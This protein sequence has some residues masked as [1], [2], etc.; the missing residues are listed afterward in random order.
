[1][2]VCLVESVRLF[3][4]VHYVYCGNNLP[5][6]KKLRLLKTKT[7][8]LKKKKTE[9]TASCTPTLI[10]NSPLSFSLSCLLRPLVTIQRHCP[11]FLLL[12]F[13]W[14]TCTLLPISFFLSF[15]LQFNFH[16]EETLLFESTVTTVPTFTHKEKTTYTH[17]HTSTSDLKT[18]FRFTY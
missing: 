9:K 15:P 7:I 16:P 4:W 8:A 12:L 10:R 1:M 6:K 3:E 14:F 2:Y 17:T 13:S 11:S 18:R 5:K